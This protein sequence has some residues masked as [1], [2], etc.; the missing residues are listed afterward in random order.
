MDAHCFL[1]GSYVENVLIVWGPFC[2]V[3]ASSTAPPR[4]SFINR[5]QIMRNVLKRTSSR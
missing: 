2:R 3:V 5:G 1:K 4:S